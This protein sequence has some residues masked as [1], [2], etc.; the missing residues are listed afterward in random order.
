MWEFEFNTSLIVHLAQN[1]AILLAFSVMYEHFWLK[2][3]SND[4]KWYSIL[5]GL[6]IGFIGVIL[7]LTPWTLAPG[8]NFD[9]RSVLLSV[10]GLFFGGFPTLIAAIV[11]AAFRFIHGGDGLA[12]G[13]A[14][15]VSSS[16]IGV[17]WKKLR[18]NWI[19]KNHSKELLLMGLVVNLILLGCAFLLPRNIVYS[20]IVVISIPILMI[21]LPATVLIG[22]LMVHQRN[23][24]LNRNAKKKLSESERR[25]F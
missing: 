24:F 11:T 6:V 10:S 16:T 13:I 9:T 21:C 5:T 19:A 15:I 17:T 22:D 20:T 23:N 18:P 12:M 4:N 3:A 14:I 25:Y 2:K 1:A 7:M 8:I